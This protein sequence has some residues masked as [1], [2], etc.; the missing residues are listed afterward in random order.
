LKFPIKTQTLWTPDAIAD[1]PPILDFEASSLSDT[2]YPISAG[3][4]VAGRVYYWIIKPK[5]DWIDWS[6][7]SQAIHGLNRSYIEE[8]GIPAQQVCAELMEILSGHSVIYSDARDWESMW[9]TRLGLSAIRVADILELVAIDQ[10]NVFSTKRDEIFLT[11]NL[12]LHR[13]DHDALA[14]AL[15]C[16]ALRLK[17]TL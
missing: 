17:D 5:A 8:Y 11:H 9:L 15:T 13:A 16:N 7:E 3:L 4:V 12:A 10:R 6:L 2:S 14:I 1:L